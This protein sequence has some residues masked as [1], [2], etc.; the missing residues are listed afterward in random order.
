VR[1][2]MFR[3]NDVPSQPSATAPVYSNAWGLSVAR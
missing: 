2:G 1:S 3:V